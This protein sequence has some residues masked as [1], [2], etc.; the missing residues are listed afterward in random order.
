MTGDRGHGGES[1]GRN[2]SSS[3]ARPA[4]NSSIA[5]AT[6]VLCAGVVMAWLFWPLSGE[7]AVVP[8]DADA[9]GQA[10]AENAGAMAARYGDTG[11]EGLHSPTGLPSIAGSR[12]EDNTV[13][14]PTQV[15]VPAQAGSGGAQVTTVAGATAG[16]AGAAAGATPPGPD[17][18]IDHEPVSL[19]ISGWVVDDAGEPVAEIAVTAS[20]RRLAQDGSTGGPGGGTA[21]ALTDATGYFAFDD[22]PDG[23]YLLQTE[24]TDQYGSA[25]SIVRTGVSSAVLRVTGDKGAPVTIYGVVMA[26]DG[27]PIAGA[28]VAPTDE[29]K[30]ATTDG[31][32]NYSLELTVD[33]RSRT[34]S[35][36]FTKAGYHAGILGVRQ[37]QLRDVTAWRLDARLQ[38]KGGGVPVDGTVMGENG[39]PV[40]GARVQL[41]SRSLGRSH[42][43][44]SARD[45]SF[46]LDDVDI[47][48][49]YRLWVRPK[50]DFHDYVDE[51]LPVGDGGLYLPVVLQPLGTGSLRGVMVD[52]FGDPI[53]HYTLWMWNG[54]AGAN[55][56]LAVTSG[57]NGRF[58]VDNIPAG[59]VTFGSRGQP[60]FTLWGVRLEA[61]QTTTADLVLDWGYEEMAGRLVNPNNGEPVAGAEVTLSWAGGEQGVTSRSRRRTVAD[62]GG[63]FIF[64]ELGPGLHTI[65]VTARGYRPVRH[66]AMP[67]EE[68][69][70]ELQAVAP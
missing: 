57:S 19:P 67:G 5:I 51:G 53:P 39:T 63:Y 64:T 50:A 47:G 21:D 11:A 38:A 16:R 41:Y 42:L 44:T 60:E 3:V 59:E 10:A 68:I 66:E 1:Y 27:R 18:S 37:S 49:D 29:T 31:A 23:E 48:D 40:S 25:H 46:F 9:S 61:G 54:G 33:Q 4:K 17:P 43:A 26:E 6:L 52:A 58:R 35:I 70:I 45:G 55:R 15:V 32:G 62:G 12:A 28:R 22:L 2:P 14:A 8:I 65:G 36:R 69:V 20:A 34:R 13:V 56:N 24:T 7:Q 30:A